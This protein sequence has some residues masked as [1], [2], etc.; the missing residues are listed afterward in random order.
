MFEKVVS[1]FV[2][3]LLF[4][5]VLG[6]KLE[7]LVSGLHV[8]AQF[9]KDLRWTRALDSKMVIRRRNSQVTTS[10]SFSNLT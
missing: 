8:F 9:L 3:Y 1:T 6:T 2:V 10:V 4:V 5:E 7:L